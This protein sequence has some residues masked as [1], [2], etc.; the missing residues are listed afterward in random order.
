VFVPLNTRLT[1][2]ELAYILADSAAQVLVHSPTLATA[3]AELRSGL[4]LVD[5]DAYQRMSADLPDG[6]LD[7]PVDPNEVSM[8]MYTS[9][10]TGHPKGVALSHAN[11]V[12]NSLNLLIDVDLTGDEVTLVNAPMFHVAALNQTVLPTVLKGGT[13]V[14]EPTFDPGRTLEL[15]ERHRVTY[16]FGVPAMFQAIAATPGWATADLSSV[17]TMICGGAPVPETLIAAYQRRGLTF[18]QGYGLTES[19][20]GALFLRATDGLDKIGSAGTPCFFTDVNVLGADGTEVKPGEPGEVVVHGPNVM[21]GYWNKP[22]ETAAVLSDDGW[23]RTGDIAVRDADGYVYIRDRVKDMIISGGENIYP[24]EVED[25]LYRHPAIADCAVIG[26]P[27]QRW[28][29]VGRAIVVLREDRTAD[30]AELLDFLR[31][32]IANYKIPKSVVFTTALPR[33]ASGKI[34]KKQLRATHGS[35]S[36]IIHPGTPG[37]Q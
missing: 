26:V 33:T 9:G 4:H 22:D 19:A 18:L 3:A 1:V 12:W 31:G 17:R 32:K 28:G 30:A 15:I 20:P 14:L 10:T 11:L 34:L 7:E 27:D 16:L 8:I 35:G 5:F 36:A 24:A 37:R 2:P 23:L 13:M 25:V 6:T 21:T 29:E